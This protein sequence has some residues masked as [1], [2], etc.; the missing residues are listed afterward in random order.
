MPVFNEEKFITKAIGLVR[1]AKM[2][3]IIKE[4]VVVDDGSTDGTYK[5]LK[6]VKTQNLKGG[7]IIKIVRLKK[8]RGKGAAIRE[9]LKIVTGQA[10]IIQDADLEYNPSEIILLLQPI[11]DGYADVT[12]GSRFMSNR[13]HRVLF[14]WHMIGNNILTL[15][16]N[17]LTNLNLTDME[18]GYKAFRTNILRQV[19][20]EE[21]RFGFEPEVTAKI[22]KLNCRVYEVGISYQGRKYEDGKKI[23]WGD[24]FWALWCI[25]KYNLL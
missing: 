21:D 24:G 22:A 10:V 7:N 4:I 5:R 25:V 12:F 2:G 23:G 16:S 17:M 19:T 9:A 11:M 1:K 13:P 3:K 18:T 15:V 6:K 8:N 20:I 14:F